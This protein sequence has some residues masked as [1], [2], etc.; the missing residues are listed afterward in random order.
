M[1]NYFQNKLSNLLKG[2]V[3]DDIIMELSKNIKSFGKYEIVWYKDKPISISLLSDKYESE[4][5]GEY[6]LLKYGYSPSV[7]VSNLHYI[8][9]DISEHR[10]NIINDVLYK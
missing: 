6:W 2:L 4:F 1:N 9:F 3:S 8:E 7:V 5:D 10:N